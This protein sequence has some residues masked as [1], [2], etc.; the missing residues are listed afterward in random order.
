MAKKPKAEVEETPAADPAAAPQV[1]AAEPVKEVPHIQPGY[2]PKIGDIVHF[3]KRAQTG[4]GNQLQKLAAI[5]V[6]Y[7]PGSS[8]F[9]AKDFA[10][11]VQ[12]F[13]GKHGSPVREVMFDVT[14]EQKDG[15]WGPKT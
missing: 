12:I 3:Y 1:P 11:E 5:V 10:I 14:G 13:Q 4:A 15:R 6:A 2:L 8:N 9:Q 7:P